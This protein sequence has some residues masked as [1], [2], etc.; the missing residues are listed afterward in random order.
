MQYYPTSCDIEKIKPKPTMLKVS[1]DGIFAT[2]QGEGLLTKEG[3]TAGLPAVFL[4]LHFCNLNCGLYGGWQCDTWYTWDKR[5]K[6]FW[7]EP[8]D[9]RF[10]ETAQRIKKEWLKKFNNINEKRLVITGG[11]PLLQQEKIVKVLSFLK[12]WN[13]EIETNGTI[14]PAK[15]LHKY[16]F[17]CSPKLSNSGNLLGKRYKPKVLRLINS[18]PN[19]WFKF[20]VKSLQDLNEVSTVVKNCNLDLKKILIMPEGY[21]TEIVSKHAN[22]IKKEVVKKGW[23]LIKRYQLIWFGPKRKT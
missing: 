18:L 14:I 21:T 23:R 19:S 4:R 17:N 15:E 7:Q 1:G 20:V 10:K 3:G 8:Q 13:V 12:G 22:M 5:R 2:L 11:E 6:E 9:W 16:Q